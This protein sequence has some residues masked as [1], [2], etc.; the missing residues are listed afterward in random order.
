MIQQIK[1]P[2]PPVSEICCHDLEYVAIIAR[3]WK[4]WSGMTQQIKYLAPPVSEICCH[5]QE[6]AAV[7][8]RF[9]NR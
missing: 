5:D 9:W 8:A 7:M 4:R 3:V 1:Y 6:Y 2:A